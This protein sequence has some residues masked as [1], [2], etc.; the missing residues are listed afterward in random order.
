LT[1]LDLEIA[2]IEIDPH[3][4]L[5]DEITTADLEESMRAIGLLHPIQVVPR[6]GGGY[7][8]NGGERRLRAAMALGWET[9]EARVLEGGNEIDIELAAIDENIVRRDLQG[10][11]LD[12]ALARRKELYLQKFPDTAAHVAGGKARAAGPEVDRPR[13]FVEDTADKTGKSPRTIERSVR[14]AERL[15]PATMKAYEEGRITQSQADVLAGR[16]WE[17]QDR[18][19]DHVVGRSVEETRRIVAGEPAESGPAETGPGAMKHLE[20]LYM[21]GQKIVS[22]LEHLGRLR[23]LDPEFVESVLNLRDSLNEEFDRFADHARGLNDGLAFPEEP[24]F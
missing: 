17:D 20:D 23:E 16:P 19:L 22:V 3:R 10:A 13:S 18:V 15:S 8:L 6:A 9:I 11:S 2:S 21:H 24:P 4:N 1:I 14:R 12:R 7:V 5:R